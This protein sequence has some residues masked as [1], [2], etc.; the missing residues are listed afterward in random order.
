MRAAIRG[1]RSTR[2]LVARRGLGLRLGDRSIGHR[3]P[4]AVSC[5]LLAGRPGSPVTDRSDLLARIEAL[6][7]ESGA[8][9]LAA[10]READALFAQYQLSQLVAS[11]G[12]VPEL[13]RSVA[14]EAVR[15]GAMDGG[16]LWLGDAA[17]DAPEPGP[18]WRRSVRRSRLASRGRRR[19]SPTSTRADAGARHCP[20]A[21]PSSS[22]TSRR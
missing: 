20:V 4:G 16:A 11:G 7:R 17:A 6:E 12:T 8:S 10:Q 9:F 15:L 13:A 3:D 14:L 18:A 19:R 2:G 1:M 5:L 21:E 22:P